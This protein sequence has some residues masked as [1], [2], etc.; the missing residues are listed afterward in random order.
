MVLDPRTF[1]FYSSKPP[2]LPMVLAGEYWL[3]KHAFGWSITDESAI[4][5]RVILLTV[6]ALPFF[7]YLL[8]LARM[9]DQFGSTD[10]GRFYVVTAAC[11]ATFMTPFLVTLNNHTV[12][13]C[14]VLL[15]LYPVFRSRTS[16]S[17]LS[18]VALVVSGLCAGL[19]VCDELPALAFLAVLFSV[20]ALQ[21]PWRTLAFFAPAAAIPLAAL[22]L[23]NYL[24]IGD[25]VPAYSKVNSV[26]YK[27]EGGY[28]SMKAGIDNAA[29]S[30]NKLTY[31]FHLL[32]GH[33]GLFSLSPIYILAMAGI[34]LSLRRALS[35]QSLSPVAGEKG[36]GEGVPA[37]LLAGITLLLTLVVVGFYIVAS[38]N[39]G[40][41]TS[42]PRWF[43]WLTPFWLL[44][45]LPAVDW[46]GARRWGRIL[47]YLLLALSV[48][49]VSYPV[50]NPWHHP[51]IY[52]LLQTQGW[53]NYY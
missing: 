17:K 34:V 3:L 31:A 2:L 22:L 52:R 30:E 50:W 46:L 6:N 14:C 13:T 37:R 1:R 5:I 10:W 47:G 23:T 53:I 25:I 29:A 42:G 40:G 26:W 19:A 45:M 35:P 43:M 21:A 51:W 12:A 39:Y 28:W 18:P 16:G 48:F 41:G 24:A 4:V 15:A 33:H 9:C 8:L 7:I 36:R 44:A 32:L 27:F 20:L 49:S 11:F 38:D